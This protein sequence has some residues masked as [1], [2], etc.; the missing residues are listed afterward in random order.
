MH[1]DVPAGSAPAPEYLT[2]R[3]ALA[4]AVAIAAR[5]PAAGPN[6]RVGCVILAPG[7]GTDPRRVLATGF[8]RGAGTPHAEVAALADAQAADI[9]V[10]GASVFVSLEP[11]AHTGRTGP[12]ADA[13]VAARV[14]EV[15]Y[16]VADPS[17]AAHGGGQRLA[18]AGIAVVGPTEAGQGPGHDLV[19]A[20]LHSVVTGR[21]YVTLKMATTLDGRVAAADGTSRW[22]TS[23]AARHRAH[24]HRAEVDAILVGTGTALADDPA[25]TA[26]VEPAPGSEGTTE[27]VHQPLRVV[28]GRTEIPREARLRR[29]P[30][31]RLVLLPTHDVH[32][33]L[34][35]L[36]ALEVRHV[37]VEGGPRV[38]A[39]FLRAG[40][41][42]EV[43]AYVAPVILGA[44]RGAVADLGVTSISQA[45]RLEP[46]SVE[47][48][49]PDVLIVSRP[50]RASTDAE[51]PIPTK[52]S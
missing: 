5:G 52:E 41:V 39:Q 33:A 35:E 23:Q 47:V 11:C 45:L 28:L 50:R 17:P 3:E 36:A 48:L 18:R 43:H 8:H 14:A 49:G 34:A 1:V 15:T 30:G 29:V 26:R 37:L 38:A 40:L 19:R 32:E 2:P 4:H 12:C 42:D 6:P 13:L 9:D 46:V 51:D 22:V 10:S 24:A 21:P 7:E 20:W 16:A 44:G 27:G 25:L 31:G